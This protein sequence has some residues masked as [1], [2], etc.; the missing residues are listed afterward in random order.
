MD[1]DECQRVYLDAIQLSVNDKQKLGLSD[2]YIYQSI[3]NAGLTLEKV[4]EGVDQLLQNHPENLQEGTVEALLCL[5][6]IVDPPPDYPLIL[7]KLLL[8]TNH[9]RHEDI[10]HTLQGFK[11]LRTVDALFQ[12]ALVIHDHLHYDEFFGLAR[13]CTWA[14]ADIGTPEA[15]SKLQ[16]LAKGENQLIA[17]YAQKRI[18][19]WKSERHRKAHK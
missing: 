18:D 2:K 6:R 15:L 11:D 13:K 10:A 9:Q 8:S 3:E 12:A 19:S 4:K 17:G 14:L 16:L 5:I 7:A 1:E